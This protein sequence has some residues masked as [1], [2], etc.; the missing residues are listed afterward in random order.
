MIS[1]AL[2]VIADL[3]A[4]SSDGGAGGGAGSVSAQAAKAEDAARTAAM[5]RKR[6]KRRQRRFGRHFVRNP[7]IT[8]CRISASFASW[9]RRPKLMTFRGDASHRR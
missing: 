2:I 1:D 3:W 7:N 5:R 4:K 8:H 9:P 6:R